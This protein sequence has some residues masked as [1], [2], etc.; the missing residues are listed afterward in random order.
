[1]AAA[2]AEGAGAWLAAPNVGLDAVEAVGPALGVV[3]DDDAAVL[4]ASFPATTPAEWCDVPAHP[5]AKT[6]NPMNHR[7]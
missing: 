6:T 4:A 1:M 5:V 3:V 2:A 7:E